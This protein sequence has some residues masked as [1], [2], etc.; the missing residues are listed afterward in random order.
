MRK[1]LSNKNTSVPVSY[2]YNLKS[3]Q[4]GGAGYLLSQEALFR[5]GKRL[6]RN[7]N[8]CPDTGVEDRDM[9]RCL[10]K[11]NVNQGKSVDDNGRERFHPYNM[12][13][14]YEGSFSRWLTDSAEN[15]PKKV[16]E[17]F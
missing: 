7:F 4:S 13:T 15:P 11:L 9:A 1:F 10:R 17:Q 5:L 6:N 14:H 3:Y 12:R 8:S 16:F 2:G